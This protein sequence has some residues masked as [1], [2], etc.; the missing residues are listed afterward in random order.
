MKTLFI[1]MM[2]FMG[3][4]NAKS[5]EL[6]LKGTLN[7]VENGTEIVIRSYNINGGVN[8]QEETRLL[9]KEGMFEFKKKLKRP[10]KFAILTMPKIPPDNPLDFEYCDVW[11]EN[12]HMT[13]VGKKGEI[14]SSMVTGSKIHEEYGKMISEITDKKTESRELLKIL[15]SSNSLSKNEKKAMSIQRENLIAEISKESRNFILENPHYY[16][17][18]QE[19]VFYINHFAHALTNREIRTFYDKMPQELKS[20]L[21]GEQIASFLNSGKDYSDIV[22]L[23]IGDKPHDF[24]LPNSKNDSVTFSNIN[25]KVVLLDFWASGCGPCRKEHINYVALYEKYKDKGFEIVS[26]SQDRSKKRWLNA[27]EKDKMTWISLLDADGQLSRIDYLVTALPTNFLI[28]KEGIII[29][30]NLRGEALKNI[31]E[32]QFQ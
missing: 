11:A 28:N 8:M 22:P 13:L 4:M 7:G 27:M 24:I 18:G 32:K 3:L 12:T 10:T 29:E 20:D 6:I 25:G 31:L 9:L 14:F 16:F 5:Q 30:K 21:Y 1:T 23:Q 26:V 19:I 15:M 2:V 17:T